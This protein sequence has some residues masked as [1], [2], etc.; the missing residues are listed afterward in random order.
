[1]PKSTLS[2]ELQCWW[3][4]FCQARFGLFL[5]GVGLLLA[6]VAQLPFTYAIDVGIAE[7]YKSD[8]PLL[9]G[10]NAAEDDEHGTYRWT[11]DGSWLRLP[12]I[13]ER[14]LLVELVFGPVSSH[15]LAV[16]PKQVTLEVG[17]Q[18]Y[19]KVKV[20]ERGRVLKMLLKPQLIRGG[21]LNLTFRSATFTL[22]NDSRRLGIP[23]YGVNVSSTLTPMTL[24]N[25]AWRVLG[26]WVLA[27][28]GVSLSILRGLTLKKRHLSQIVAWSS[29]I[30]LALL[31]VLAASL[32]RP[33]WGYGAEPALIVAVMVCG[34]SWLLRLSL[35]PIAQRSE[36]PLDEET[37]EWLILIVIV[38]FSLRYGGRLYPLSMWGDIGFHTN[39]LNEVARGHLFILSRNRGINFPYPS[40]PYLTLLPFNLLYPKPAAVIQLTAS[41]VEPLSGTLLYAMVA[42]TCQACK[43]WGRA[44]RRIALGAPALYL[45]TAAGL[46]TN[47]WAFATHIYAQAA[48]LLLLTTL[49]G[50]ALVHLNGPSKNQTTLILGVLLLGIFLGHFGFFINTALL[51]SM[52]LG[53]LILGGNGNKSSF[54]S[55]GIGFSGALGLAFLLFYSA[56]TP[57]LLEQARIAAAGGLT[58]LAQRAPVRRGYLWQTLWEAGLLRHFGFFPLI[59]A[60]LGLW[61]MR[62]WG[63][64]ARPLIALSWGSL[65]VSLAF[66]GLPFLT[67]STQSTRWLMFSAWAITLGTAIAVQSLWRRGRVSQIVS[68]TL[69]GF[70][71]WNTALIW[72]GPLAW[73]IRPPEPF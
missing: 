14:P 11:K 13:G 17:G 54:W 32:D 24:I 53:F 19:L 39:R 15:V 57:M 58:T 25:P 27:L 62:T 42:Q 23:L 4:V 2:T 49:N 35:P 46:M 28:G 60:P 72:L 12:G 3:Q 47:W 65:L 44:Q 21:E 56:F 1:M 68:L 31:L 66:A 55:L 71:A 41:L 69:L 48:T 20:Q 10:F 6:L 50:L 43:C 16:G 37:L 9:W 70:V 64:N 45:L 29:V 7:G 73:R 36:V 30:G 67:L 51:V 22:P 61:L 26:M 18:A 63:A 33:R 34:L 52:L 40:G 5:A 59:L 38:G 8:L